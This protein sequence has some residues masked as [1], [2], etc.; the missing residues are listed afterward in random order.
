MQCDSSV[1]LK[2]TEFGLIDKNT[3]A[4]LSFAPKLIINDSKQGLKVFEQIKKELKTCKSF[5][6]S[7]AFITHSGVNILLEILKELEKKDIKGRIITSNYLNFSEPKAIE[8]LNEFKNLT[9]KIYEKEAF[10]I[11]GYLFEQEDYFSLFVGSS[12]LTQAALLSNKEWNLKVTSKENG[13]LINNIN[14]EFITLWKDSI[15]LTPNWLEQYKKK[16][17]EIKKLRDKVSQINIKTMSLEP[18]MMQV[19]AVEALKKIR[20]SGETRAILI[21]ATGTGKTY[22]SAF[23]VKN[24]KPKKFLFL[25]HREQLLLQAEE[26][27][28]TVLGPEINT[29]FLS[30]KYKDY[31]CDYLFSTMNMMAKEEIYT[32][33]KKDEFDYIIIDEAHR[34]PSYSYQKIINYFKPKFLFGMTATPSRTD[35]KDVLENFDKNIA[36]KIDLKQAMEYNL[37]CPF[38]YFG[39]SEIYIDGKIVDDNTN[40]NDL[41]SDDRVKNII[42]KIKFYGHSGDRVKGLIFTRNVK[43]AELLSDKF[44]KNGYKT[45]A[46]SASNSIEER[47]KAIER[48]ESDDIDN[49]NLDYIFSVDIFN[50]GVDIPSVNQIILLRPTKSAVIF[51]QQLGRG[52]RKYHDKE[53]VVVLDFIGNYENNYC[54]PMALSSD[55][56]FNRETIRKTVSDGSAFLSGCSTIEFDQISRHQIY[57]AIDNSKLSTKKNIKE[58]YKY[59]KSELS[60]IP[61][62]E[63]FNK[64]AEIDF[65]LVIENYGS[66]YQLIKECE[67]ENSPYTL[68]N[69]E[70]FALNYLSTKIAKGKHYESINLLNQLIDSNEKV[71]EIQIPYITKQQK[72]AYK[73]LSHQYNIIPKTQKSIEKH[74]ACILVEK[75]DNYIKPTSQLKKYLKNLTFINC[76][77][78]IIDYSISQYNENYKNNYKNTQ[79]TLFKQYSYEEV[80]KALNWEKDC[81]AVMNG[82]MYDKNTN[83]LPVFINY[84]KEE[85]AINYQDHFTSPTSIIAISKKNRTIKSIDWQKIYRAKE[86][87]TKIYLFV[88][89]NK[90]TNNSKD[91]YFLG[92]IYPQGDAIPIKIDNTSA[93]KINYTLETPVRDDIYEYF[94]T[95]E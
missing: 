61:S 76:I 35:A 6:F 60:H 89:K 70:L 39:I 32:K 59:L 81:S 42:E 15:N 86:N 85:D 43:E 68:N 90:A 80:C 18:N 9:I 3:E 92:E 37:L 17:L 62:F 20:N 47:T 7:V 95:A 79:L 71:A 56:S 69:E 1:L 46:L 30:G 38:H 22:L 31:N 28:K 94:T 74:K 2:A 65:N 5:C 77:K 84:E 88:R 16:Y 45:I 54:I 58:A 41:G 55:K 91:F 12:N 75:F 40:I 25:A 21:S 52:L 82:Y 27:Y 53:F 78:E 63:E 51:T 23:D 36:L 72:V 93:F 50:E 24:Y 19:K 64:Y 14:S 73:I 48:L 49:S 83:T 44:N 57:S 33:F 8:R 34:S 67:K 87:N 13:N 26:S 10:H 29:G 4:N 66:Y 11:K